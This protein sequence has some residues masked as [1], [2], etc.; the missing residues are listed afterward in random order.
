MPLASEL[1]RDGE[2]TDFQLFKSVDANVTLCGGPDSALIKLQA[3]E[4][5]M[6]APLGRCL[7]LAGF[8][9]RHSPPF[10][11]PPS[12]SSPSPPP[13]LVPKGAHTH[14]RISHPA[15]AREI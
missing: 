10:A 3:P 1:G 9:V 13:I 14:E 4:F 8:S 7:G 11:P 2:Q 6:H 12:S 5:Q 15:P